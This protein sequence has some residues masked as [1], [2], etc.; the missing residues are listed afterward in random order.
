M[1]SEFYLV[2]I[3]TIWNI[4][5]GY[6]GHI[7]FSRDIETHMR[8]Q[9]TALPEFYKMELQNQLSWLP[10]ICYL[11]VMVTRDFFFH[12]PFH[13][14]YHS[15]HKYEHSSTFDAPDCLQTSLL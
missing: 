10:E 7:V 5:C 9:I 13:F 15:N 1:I 8:Y 2:A 6:F 4:S 11:V 12:V 14:G 3:I